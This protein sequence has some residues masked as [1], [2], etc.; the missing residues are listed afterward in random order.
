MIIESGEGRVDNWKSF[1]EQ[2]VQAFAVPIIIGKPCIFF[3]IEENK[4][5]LRI[6]ILK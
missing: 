5:F 1:N 6:S 2:E 3:I 4:T